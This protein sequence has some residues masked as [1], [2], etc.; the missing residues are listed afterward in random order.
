MLLRSRDPYQEFMVRDNGP[1]RKEVLDK[2]GTSNMDHFWEKRYTLV[3]DNVPDFLSGQSE[4]ILRTGK[5]LNVIR[6]SG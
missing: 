3:P 1:P 5:Y 6:M 4:L 2:A